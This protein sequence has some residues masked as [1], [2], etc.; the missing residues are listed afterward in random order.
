MPVKALVAY[1][2]AYGFPFPLGEADDVSPELMRLL[3]RLLDYY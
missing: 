2:K 3:P 1:D